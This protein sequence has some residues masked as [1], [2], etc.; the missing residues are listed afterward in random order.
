MEADLRDFEMKSELHFMSFILMRGEGEIILDI[1]SLLG[2]LDLIDNNSITQRIMKGI[3]REENALE[4]CADF[5]KY[6]SFFFLRK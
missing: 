2:K 4:I 3:R 5:E 6:K 1:S